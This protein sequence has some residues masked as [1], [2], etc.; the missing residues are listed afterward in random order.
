MK[1]LTASKLYDYI[2]CPHKV[3]RDAYG[4]QDEKI[5]E[6][7]PFVQMLW[8]RGV[9]HEKNVIAEMGEYLDL[10]AGSLG[11]RFE[12]TIEAIKNG[13][14]LIYQGVLKF[15]NYLGIP[16][17]LKR[18]PD[19]KYVPVDIKSGSGVEGADEEFEEE[20]KPKPHYAVQLCFYIELLQ[21]LGLPNTGTGK[22]I[23]IHKNEIE[24]NLNAS[25]EKET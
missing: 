7:N 4:P 24:Y 25:K 14:P 18:M 5:Q 23:D 1:T 3:W 11:E 12:K 22:I 6:T 13:I 21:K 9:A 16:D 8:E 2:K 20:G 19:G 17:L 15:E 10:S